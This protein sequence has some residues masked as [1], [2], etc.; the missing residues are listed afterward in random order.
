MVPLSGSYRNTVLNRNNGSPPFSLQV[1]H[2]SVYD[3]MFTT[4]VYPSTYTTGRF[5][6][7]VPPPLLV[8][9]QMKSGTSTS[10]QYSPC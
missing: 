2:N 7:S 9:S 4:L 10:R 3:N 8:L 6:A 1:V 5:V